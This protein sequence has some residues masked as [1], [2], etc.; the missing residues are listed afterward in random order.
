MRTELLAC[1]VSINIERTTVVFRT[2][3]SLVAERI[4]DR[5]QGWQVSLFTEN[6][7]TSNVH[8]HNDRFNV[9]SKRQGSIV[10]VA[11]SPNAYIPTVT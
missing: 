10:A 2:F 1:S 8:L 5:R 9:L 4:R 11:H 3:V 7:R 6:P